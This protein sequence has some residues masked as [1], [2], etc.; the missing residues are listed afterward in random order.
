MDGEQ[1][2]RR[3]AGKFSW[4]NEAIAAPALC[5]DELRSSGT[6]QFRADATHEDLEI[7][8]ASLVVAAPHAVEQRLVGQQMARVAHQVVQQLVLDR[9]QLDL[10]PAHRHFLI[11]EMDGQVARLEV[12]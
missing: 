11:L 6:T 7:L 5:L 8:G 1:L 9:C 4:A 3:L 10:L 12:W 2:A